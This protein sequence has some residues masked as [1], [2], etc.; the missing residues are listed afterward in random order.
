VRK[1]KSVEEYREAIRAIKAHGI[2]VHGSF[3]F[4]FDD[5]TPDLFHS[6]MEFA[7][8]N[9]LDVANYCTLTPYPGTKLFE[10]M[11]REGRLLHKNWSLYDRYNIVFRPRNFSVEEF[12]RLADE[13]YRKTYSMPSILRRTPGVIKNI[14]YYYAINLSYWFGAKL[15]RRS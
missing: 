2:G 11:D 10:K 3:V 4:G 12:R 14:P 7:L 9:K 8:K 6:T 5:D 15:R 13:I 1:L